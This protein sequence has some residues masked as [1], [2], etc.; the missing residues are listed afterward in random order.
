MGWK[1]ESIPVFI[2]LIF[3]VNRM[4]VKEITD[5]LFMGKYMNVSKHCPSVY[6]KTCECQKSLTICL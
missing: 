3:V 6:R 2:I 5:H 4:R 1:L